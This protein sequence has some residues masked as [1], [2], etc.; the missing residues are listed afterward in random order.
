MGND[1]SKRCMGQRA[2]GAGGDM[3]YAGSIQEQTLS[4]VDCRI[5]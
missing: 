1:E 3:T 4:P 2:E 5:S